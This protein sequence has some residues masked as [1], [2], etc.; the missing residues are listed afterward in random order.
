MGPGERA[1]ST[2][3]G[4][5]WET[6]PG[7][8]RAGAPAQPGAWPPAARSLQTRGRGAEGGRRRWGPVRGAG[9]PGARI[10]SPVSWVTGLLRVAVTPRAPSQPHLYFTGDPTS[11]YLQITLLVFVWH[12]HAKGHFCHIQSTCKSL[13]DLMGVMLNKRADVGREDQLWFSAKKCQWLLCLS[14][15]CRS[16]SRINTLQ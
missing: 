10:W 12:R 6:R 15:Y 2:R 3:D 1:V 4:G 7:C 9:S 13:N 8:W 14:S 11:G 5:A 16:R